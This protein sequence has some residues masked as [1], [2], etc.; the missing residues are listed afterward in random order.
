MKIGGGFLLSRISG[1][2]ERTD[3]LGAGRGPSDVGTIYYLGL[4]RNTNRP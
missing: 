3:F 4:V 2:Q 1:E